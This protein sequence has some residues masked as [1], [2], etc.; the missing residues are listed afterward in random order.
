MRRLARLT[1]LCAILILTTLATLPPTHAQSNPV[2][3]IYYFDDLQNQLVIER[4]DGTDSRTFPDIAP[5]E[6][7][8]SSVRGWSPSGRWFTLY[9][10]YTA[11]PGRGTAQIHLVSTDGQ[12]H[13]PLSE[14][15]IGNFYVRWAP[16][17]DVLLIVHMDYPRSGGTLHMQILDV[18]QQAMLADFRLQYVMGDF[19]D[20]ISLDWSRNGQAAY[21]SWSNYAVILHRDGFVDAMHNIYDRASQQP[22]VPIDQGRLFSVTGRNSET[23]TLRLQDIGTGQTLDFEDRIGRNLYPYRL[24]WSPT[25]D[26]ALLY[27]SPCI[28]DACEDELQLV[29]WQA[30]TLTP[31]TPTIPIN[32]LEDRECGYRYT[33]AQLWSPGG[34]FA[35]LTDPADEAVYLLDVHTGVM[36]QITAAIYY[37]WMPDEKLL[38]HTDSATLVAYDPVTNRETRIDLPVNPGLQE[39]DPSPDGQLLGIRSHPPTVTDRAGNIIA[40]TIPHSHSMRSWIEPYYGYRWHPDQ[41]WLMAIYNISFGGGGMGPNA[42]VVFNLAGTVRRELPTGG[43]ANFVPERALP[44]LSPGQPT[45]VKKDPIFTLVHPLMEDVF[46]VGWHPTDPDQLVTYATEAGLVFWSLAGEEPEITRQIMSSTPLP[47]YNWTVNLAWLPDRDIV[48]F[49]T[50]AGMLMQMDDITGESIPVEGVAYPLLEESADGYILRDAATGTITPLHVDTGCTPIRGALPVNESS[51]IVYVDDDEF[52]VCLADAMAGA[53]IPLDINEM[54][55]NLRGDVS[56]SSAAFSSIYAR[57]ITIVSTETGAVL[58]RFY[59]TAAALA[60]SSDGRR[61]AT[62]ARGITNIWDVSGYTP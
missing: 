30:G 51:L 9:S 12:Q 42:A 6:H 36:Q 45:S 2:P 43:G 41:Q 19:P 4:A 33:C 13:I 47:G 32:S 48:A 22:Y 62:T 53:I 5:E 50:T 20:Q 16:H 57:Y 1:L 23:V 11:G 39:F 40:Q 26:H 38:I 37:Q 7:N 34:N 56:G 28:D 58:D 31:L 52:S 21:V 44:Y 35:V 49:Y 10:I 60:I 27:I 29:D 61:L 46:G 14:P 18:E 3:Y 15:S 54:P 55:V 24:R 59:G 25:L 8:S 17:D